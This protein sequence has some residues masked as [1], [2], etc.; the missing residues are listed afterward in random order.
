MGI[1]YD[2]IDLW[3]IQKYAFNFKITKIRQVIGFSLWKRTGDITYHEYIWYFPGICLYKMRANH[4]NVRAVLKLAGNSPYLAPKIESLTK[5]TYFSM[6][7]MPYFLIWVELL[8]I[9]FSAHYIFKMAAMFSC[10]LA[11][12]RLYF[13]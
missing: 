8:K 3:N 1:F 6:Y 13:T 2:A 4:H 7:Y 9:M 12:F 11:F 10:T 5:K